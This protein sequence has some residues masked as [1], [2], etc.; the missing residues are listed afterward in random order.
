MTQ[1]NKNHKKENQ[2][3]ASK[4][5][6]SFLGKVGLGLSAFIAA[7][8]II[9]G[10]EDISTENSASG[11]VFEYM[12][13]DKENFIYS[14]CL[15]CNTG[16][17][18][19]VKVQNG[20][21]VKIDGNPYSPWGRMPHLPFNTSLDDSAEVDG[22]ICPKG[23]AALM[24][25]N[26]PFRIKKVL[27]RVG[28][29]GSRKWETIEFD[30]AITEIVNGGKLFSKVSGEENRQVEG[31]KDIM[32][33]TDKKVASAMSDAIDDI[34]SSKTEDEKTEKVSDFKI[35]FADH[36]HHLIDPNYPEFGPKNNQFSWMHGRLKSGRSE[37]FKRFVQSGLGSNN[38]HGHTT[39][40]QGSL[41]FT[42]KAMSRQYT[43]DEKKKK[44]DWTGGDKFFWQADQHKAEFIIFVGSS[45]F[46]A[47]YPLLR[48]P[49]IMNGLASGRLKYA[50]VDPRYSKTCAHA[51]KWIP[52]KPGTEA[53]LAFGMI[54]WIIENEKFDKK[55]LG[56]ANKAASKENGEPTLTNASWLIK[57][58][59]GKPGKFL[60]GSDI[61]L[62]TINKKVTENE[63]DITIA[64]DPFIVLQNGKPVAFDNEDAKN[65]VNGDLFVSTT[66]KG[67]E[68]KSA[69]QLVKE[70][71]MLHTIGEWADI[72]GTTEK[73]IIELSDEFTSHGKKA[74]FD[75]HRGVSQHTNGFYNCFAGNILNLLIG[76]FDSKGG[77]VKYSTYDVTGGKAKGPYDFANSLNPGKKKTFGLN[78]L[79]PMDYE[80]STLF[81]G[82]PAK[83]P[84]FPHATDVYQEILPSIGDGYPY[85]IKALLL[86]M[87]TPGY[88]LPAGQTQINVLADVEKLPL[89]IASDITIGESSMF[90]DYIIPD[91]TFYERWEF[92]GS[93]PNNIWK[94]QTIRQPAMK[95][96]TDTVKVYGEEM[97]ISLESFMMAVAEKM[98][99]KNFGPNGF[100]EGMDFKRPE[101]FYLRM[102]ANIG[103]G[104]KADGNAAVPDATDEE[105][106]VFKEARRHL[107]KSVFD[108]EK[109]K[110]AVGDTYWRKA[111]Y[112]MNRGG[113][114]QNYE[115]A[116]IGE[117]VA[118][119][120]G[121]MV[122][123]Y[124]E[125]V[126]VSKNSI[127]GEPLVG[128][129]KY[130]PLMDSIG[131]LLKSEDGTLHMITHKE[132]FH[133][134]SRTPGNKIL[135]ELS[136]T[137]Y[138]LINS[139]DAKR[140]GLKNLD[141]VRITSD[142]NPEGV[143]ELP[144]FGKKHMIGQVKVTEGMRPGVM[145]YSLG[146][147][148]WAYGSEDVVIDNEV[149]KGDP[150]R[151][152][153][154]HANAAMMIDP[155]LKNI[156]LQDLVGGSVA[157]FDSPV[158]LEKV[159]SYSKTNM[160][161][162]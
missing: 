19:K 153:G 37:F 152:V 68:V 145:G 57:I 141:K 1:N 114:F 117:Q 90:A 12:H 135:K 7:P 157:F 35:Q 88:A 97:P 72:A 92:H 21:M 81:N 76:N 28:P 146:F 24:T 47:N 147:G 38:F 23:Q 74:V 3:S 69:L 91:L 139:I 131:N 112:L 64:M 41:Y 115:D 96:Y 49:N 25:V 80:K 120:Y 44:T 107:P 86:Y 11:E 56:G 143:W 149:I 63:Q 59:N 54:R 70:E 50:V 66:I 4:D 84:W 148:H 105:I 108:Y 89:F 138:V 46:E 159:T 119:K 126:A 5:R 15:G 40:C 124:V 26:D 52:N 156:C 71:A 60:R 118:N 53:A 34:W 100:E 85:N 77:Y 51:W 58:T 55:Y 125:K 20:A 137:N 2:P 29:R 39:V 113:R 87:G 45:P 122:N 83:R 61:G 65:T 9:Q 43:Y 129:P 111:V 136:P 158:R 94:V 154:F 116:Y 32:S 8:H 110:K 140:Q 109:W 36:L 132:I 162:A 142:S 130:L 102:I 67:I 18:T 62:P 133:T 75:M 82:Y 17:P 151:G 98:E 160:E 14:V 48:V 22:A 104:E 13:N 144:N 128:S 150:E 99:L 16:C 134:K 103:Y 123:M 73:D 95:P 78:I 127:T 31:L 101:D 161:L 79:R 27:K 33:L 42:G 6:R 121:K 93:H 155:H 30:Q 106:R 10:D